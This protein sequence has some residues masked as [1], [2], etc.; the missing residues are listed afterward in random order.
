MKPSTKHVICRLIVLCSFVAI[1]LKFAGAI[2]C[3]WWL[4][5][6]PFLIIGGLLAG[7]IIAIIV[8]FAVLFSGAEGDLKDL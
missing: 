6:S 2:T 4:V 3:S 7:A 5:L 8:V 1:I